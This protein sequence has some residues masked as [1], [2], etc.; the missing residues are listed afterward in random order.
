MGTITMYMAVKNADFPGL[1]A[2]SI[3]SLMSTD[4]LGDEFTLSNTARSPEWIAAAYENQKD[5]TAVSAGKI[6]T[7]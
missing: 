7:R 3:L 2:K 4:A 6:E 1:R 5:S